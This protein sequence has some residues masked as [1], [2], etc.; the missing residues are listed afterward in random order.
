MWVCFFDYEMYLLHKGGSRVK[1]INFPPLGTT[2]NKEVHPGSPYWDKGSNFRAKMSKLNK[3]VTETDKW[4]DHDPDH[5]VTSAIQKMVVYLCP[6]TVGKCGTQRLYQA[7]TPAKGS[8]VCLC[9]YV[10][11]F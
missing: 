8:L 1:G 5:N 7:L 9:W 4:V 10:L 3:I 11:Y 6:D 2:W